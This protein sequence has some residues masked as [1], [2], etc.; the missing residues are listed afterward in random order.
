MVIFHGYVSLPKGKP[1]FTILIS[2][3]PHQ[4]FFEEQLLDDVGPHFEDTP[5]R[6][7]F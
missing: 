6:S 1:W 4:Q 2:T 3:Q 5:M 7:P